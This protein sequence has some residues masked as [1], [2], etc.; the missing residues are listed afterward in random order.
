[1]EQQ[2]NANHHRQTDRKTDRQTDTHTQIHTHHT[3]LLTWLSTSAKEWTA[4]ESIAA[5]PV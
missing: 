5:D 2:M 1:M 3:A 4:S